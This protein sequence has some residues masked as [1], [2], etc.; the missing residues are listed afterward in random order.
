MS[1]SKIW[2]KITNN[3]VDETAL[4]REVIKVR[5]L[6]QLIFIA[7]ITSILTLITYIVFFDGHKII[8]TTLSNIVLEI[9]ALTL[10]YNRKHMLARHISFFVFPALIA[11]HVIIL[12]GNFGEANIFTA[13]A[14]GAFISYEGQRKLQIASFLYSCSLYAG[15]KLWAIQKFSG[16]NST[17]NPYDEILTFAMIIIVLL[18]MMFL[19][20]NEIRKYEEQKSQLINDL[21]EKNNALF[22]IN[23][24][25][26]QF[27]YIAS[28]DLKT[29]LRTIS[30]HLDL[31]TLHL[32][33]QDFEAVNVDIKYAKKGT[34]QMYMLINDILEY[35]KISKQNQSYDLVKLDQV[36]EDVLTNVQH[37][38]KK[39]NAVILYEGLPTLKVNKG[40]FVALFQN[41]IENGLKYN[42]A[43]PP[44][45][46]IQHTE[47]E[48]KILLSFED[49]GIGIYPEYHRKIFNFF[50]RLH[51]NEKYE[52]TGIGLGLCKKIVQKYY[53]SIAVNSDGINGS[54]FTVSLPIELA[55]QENPPGPSSATA[56]I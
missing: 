15:S 44:T 12:G 31:I 47:K 50:I 54:C 34:G 3:G 45:I 49:N 48:D 20:Q 25:L 23:E 6:N 16:I 7:L 13:L 33:R 52:G 1:L 36:V 53:G 11:F 41:I 35:K 5:L 29:P 43:M 2:S 18:L 28:H 37:L 4:G 26:E 27:T 8:L 32:K 19:Y 30:S 22:R 24:E 51:T 17:V 56:S 9:T 55:Q 38:I 14:F 21:E 42:D 40:D 46:K 39:K 10:A